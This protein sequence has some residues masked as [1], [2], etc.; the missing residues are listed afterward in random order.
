MEDR[1]IPDIH[2]MSDKSPAEPPPLRESTMYTDTQ[3][4]EENQWIEDATTSAES[5]LHI[6]DTSLTHITPPT[7]ARKGT[8]LS[9]VN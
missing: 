2:I 9:F 3:Q 8:N 5:M 6:I 7:Y 1:K 4:H